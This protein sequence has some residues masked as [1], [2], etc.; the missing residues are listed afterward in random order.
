MTSF[1]L[2]L[3]SHSN[4]PLHTNQLNQSPS[5]QPN[6]S[7]NDPFYEYQLTIRPISFVVICSIWPNTNPIAIVPRRLSWSKASHV[8]EAKQLITAL[9]S[10][11]PEPG[12]PPSTL[13][14]CQISKLHPINENHG[15]IKHLVFRSVLVV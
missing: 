12:S 9:S 4:I 5:P 1:V 15:T 8:P 2:R 6:G 14:G 3:V 7:L 10:P 13:S 11:G